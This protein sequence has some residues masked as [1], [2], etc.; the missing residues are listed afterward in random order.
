M[1]QSL[2]AAI[3]DVWGQDVSIKKKQSVSGGDINDAYR[4][5]L[6]NGEDAFLKLNHNASKDFFTAEAN[7]LKAMGET[8]SNV[9]NVLAYGNT[10]DNAKFLILR[11][12]ENGNR[13]S[14]YWE[15][16]GRMLANMHRAKTKGFTPNSLY[17]FYE[18]NFIF[19]DAQNF[20]RGKIFSRRFFFIC[21]S[22][23]NFCAC[24][25]EI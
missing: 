9:P 14:D 8:G 19:R 2:E 12:E 4:L 16:L 22:N 21:V 6:S 10:A 17:G 24:R 25:R 18:N 3:E 11:Y 15:S 23:K 1:Y 13:A 5:V 20:Q 7:G